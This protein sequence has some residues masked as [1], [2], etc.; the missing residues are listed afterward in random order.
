MAERPPFLALPAPLVDYVLALPGDYG[1]TLLRVAQLA[2][3]A[4]GV[5]DGIA[6]DTGEAL[7]SYRSP[8]V[9]G[10]VALDA[11]LAK[12]GEVAL[13]R[14]ALA[15]AERDGWVQIRPAH[16][17]GTASDTRTG[18][19]TSTPATIVRFL[20]F[21]EILWPASVQTAQPAAQPTAQEPAPGSGTITPVV[22]L[23]DPPA[24]PEQQQLRARAREEAKLSP[25]GALGTQFREYLLGWLGHGL[26]VAKRGSSAKVGGEL[27]QILE[28]HGLEAAL[29]WTRETLLPRLM[30]GDPGPSSMAYVVELL[31]DMPPP[32][33][34]EGATA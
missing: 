5:V 25:L 33:R 31:R 23:P 34:R 14:R 32:P 12:D 3:A 6:L 27:E 21:R 29:A 24:P 22:T 26:V 1:K 17:S 18:T 10:R 11:E 19:G 16:R 15:R 4:P 30:A 2:R 8:R 28:A 20:R 7:I 9:W 13:R